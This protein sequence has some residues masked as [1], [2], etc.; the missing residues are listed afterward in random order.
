MP[1]SCGYFQFR[2]LMWLGMNITIVKSI[3]IV[4][5]RINHFFCDNYCVYL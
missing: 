4:F 5:F 3:I 2:L 1:R